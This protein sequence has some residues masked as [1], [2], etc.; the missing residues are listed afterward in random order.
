[1][2]GTSVDKIWKQNTFQKGRRAKAVKPQAQ[3]DH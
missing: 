2:W 1:M 3:Q